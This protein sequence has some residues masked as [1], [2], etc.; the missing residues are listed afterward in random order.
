MGAFGARRRGTGPAFIRIG[1]RSVR[2]R[3]QASHEFIAEQGEFKNARS[4]AQGKGAPMSLEAMQ[5]ATMV[6]GLIRA[7]QFRDDP[8]NACS[9]HSPTLK[10][11]SAACAGLGGLR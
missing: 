3:E 5:R 1:S 8:T 9:G 7:F 4:R 10:R 2:Y 11:L 6:A